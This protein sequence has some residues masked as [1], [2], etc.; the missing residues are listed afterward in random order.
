MDLNPVKHQMTG[1]DYESTPLH[2]KPKKQ[3][4]ANYLTSFLPQDVSILARSEGMSTEARAG[5]SGRPVP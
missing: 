5:C 2:F 1:P 3:L 4:K